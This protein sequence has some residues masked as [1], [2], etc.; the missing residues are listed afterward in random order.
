MSAWIASRR[1]FCLSCLLAPAAHALGRAPVGGELRMVVPF[2]LRR[3][4]PHALD[5]PVA[6]LFAAAIADPLFAVDGLGRT[7]P[8]LAAA[9]PEPTPGGASV[10][11]RPGLVSARGSP[12]GALDVIASVE[13]A[14]ARGA[15][16]L[17][18][19][20]KRPRRHRSDPL[21]LEFS[22]AA[23]AALAQ[24]L[25][26][27]LAAVVPHNFS[28]TDPDGTGAFAARFAEG[29]LLLTRNDNGARGP[30][31]LEQITVGT[32]SD[33]A[34]A[35]RAFEAGSVDV[36]WL[37][38][39]LYRP[40]RGALPFRG[41]HYGWAILRVGKTAGRWGAPGLAQQLLD[42][43]D[44]S[45]FA[46]L[47]LEEP[48][49]ARRS[50]VQ[51]G[52]GPTTIHVLEDAPQLVLIARTLADALGRPGN[53]L[54]VVV[55]PYAEI[56]RRRASRDFSMLV[57]FVR[58]LGPKGPMTQQALLAAQDPE[59]AKKPPRLPSFDARSVTSTLTLGV[60][61]ELWVTGAHAPSCQNLAGWNL[62]NVF[63]LPETPA[64]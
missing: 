46:H 28:P 8:A 2:R 48:G 53:E 30:A 44:P 42:S 45:R 37:G 24:A 29:A 22:G 31:F 5:D 27:P 15:R 4:D 26:S 9:L 18:A 62:G 20:V 13:R 49:P 35:L 40:R 17:L 16:A 64:P 1:A 51:W 57:D 58:T 50:A 39:G 32:V 12:I 25:A 63:R 11:L 43:I 36:G 54:T 19:D 56:E 14:R 34:D 60:I 3:L 61:G 38:S 59:L 41:A 7:Y 52:G 21:A 33:L 6:A 47:G 10:K 23:P 55:E